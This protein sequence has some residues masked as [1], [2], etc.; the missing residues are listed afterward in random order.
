MRTQTINLYQFDE[1]PTAQA[2]EKARNWYREFVYTDSSDWNFVY[3]NAKKIG[4][5]IGIEI[6]N[7]SFS[8]FSCQGDGAN[9]V[10]RYKCVKGALKAVKDE[11]PTDTKL[12]EI[13]KALQDVQSRHFYKLEAK[14]QSK[15]GYYQHSSCMSVNVYHAEDEY[16]DVEDAEIE[17]TN[18]MRR[19]ADW[20]YSQ[21]ES[22]Y[23]FQIKNETVEE[24]LRSNGYEFLED[25][26]QA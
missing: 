2:K 23:E 9:F 22:D 20:I 11:C 12:H 14:L 8:G 17:I 24:N 19:F 1:L 13:A 15:A 25:G 4:A 18:L 10:G 5:L 7:I 26:S 3:E 21:L 16:K 6:D